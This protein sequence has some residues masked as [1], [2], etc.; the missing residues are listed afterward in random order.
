MRIIPT[1]FLFWAAISCVSAIASK[2]S[3][4]HEDHVSA[5][6]ES[7]DEYEYSPGKYDESSRSM[8]GG[9]NGKMNT[10]HINNGNGGDS[11]TYCSRGMASIPCLRDASLNGD[12][13]RTL[14]TCT[15][16]KVSQL[17]LQLKHGVN[18]ATAR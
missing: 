16:S 8:M 13:D 7:K 5:S 4:D 17:E 10:S 6:N 15:T 9:V 11:H 14:E 1:L 3:F 12:L 18:R 2:D